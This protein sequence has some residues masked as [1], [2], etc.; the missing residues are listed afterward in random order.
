MCNAPK[1][2][3][4]CWN[5]CANGSNIA[6]L[7]FSDHGTQEML[8]VV[9][10]NVFPFSNFA[11]E[12]PAQ[13]HAKT[14]NRVCKRTQHVTSNNVGSFWPTMLLRNYNRSTAPVPWCPCGSW[15]RK[16]KV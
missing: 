16:L 15:R 6:A 3:Q 12:L 10:L 9:G 8:G 14:R 11:Q 4:Q 1:R 13:Q 5:S 2:S 7:R